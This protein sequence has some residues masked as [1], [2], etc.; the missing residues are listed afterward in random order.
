MSNDAPK[1]T[2]TGDIKAKPEYNELNKDSKGGTELQLRALFDYLPNEVLREWQIIPSRVRE[3]KKDKRRLL[4]LHDLPQDPESQHLKDGGWK[5]FDLLVAVS[6]WQKQ[7]YM[8]FL[9]VPAHKIIVIQNAIEPIKPHKKPDAKECVNIIYH[10]TPHRGLEILIPVLKHIEDEMPDLKW[11]LDVYSSFDIYGPNWKQRN[12]PYEPLFEEIKNHP[13]MTYHGYQPNEVVREALQ[14]AHIFALPSIWPETS[15]IALIEAM[16]A[17]CL[18]VHSSLAALPETAANWSF[19]Y[20]YNEIPNEHA[21]SHAIALNDAIKILQVE[22]KNILERLRMQ[23]AYFDGFY[24]WEVRKQQ[25]VATLV[26]RQQIPS[27][28]ED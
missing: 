9:G 23:K 10:T 24:T 5:K 22:D 6:H 16:S 18:C 14:K 8:N 12:K 28:Q 1:L 7:Q 15:C 4:W 13:N 25:W 26:N 21:G 19:M 2:I 27:S 17:G 11:H 3:L 20:D